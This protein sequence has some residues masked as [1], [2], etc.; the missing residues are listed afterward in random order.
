MTLKYCYLFAFVIIIVPMMNDHLQHDHE[1][2]A[3][4]FRFVRRIFSKSLPE[5]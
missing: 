1:T 4:S 2:A 5:G 3:V